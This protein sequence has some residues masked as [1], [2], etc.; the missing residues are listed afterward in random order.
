MASS[1]KAYEDIWMHDSLSEYSERHST[2]F[3][4]W[5]VLTNAPEDWQVM[6]PPFSRI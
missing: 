1:N 6:W 2:R 4:L 5:H 3:K